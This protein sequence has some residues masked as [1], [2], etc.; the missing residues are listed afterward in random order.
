MHRCPFAHL[1]T[2]VTIMQ[3]APL[4]VLAVSPSY[5]VSLCFC[6]GLPKSYKVHMAL[7]L[8]GCMCTCQYSYE[9]YMSLASHWLH[10]IPHVAVN[11]QTLHLYL[12]SWPLAFTTFSACPPES[13]HLH[14][15][16]DQ[17]CAEP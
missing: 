2:P 6:S 3:G 10:M 5:G 13:V 7:L 9:V 4:C 12:A 14:R 1:F 11:W 17:V 15:V 16:Q 8:I